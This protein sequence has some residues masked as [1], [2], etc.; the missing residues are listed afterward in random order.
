MRK[1]SHRQRN[2]SYLDRY[3]ETINASEV[4]REDT[5]RSLNSPNSVEKKP[6]YQ[7]LEKIRKKEPGS[8]YYQQEKEQPKKFVI[9]SKL[10]YYNISKLI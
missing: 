1:N 5:R 6:L 4:R 8:Q 7:E 10:P 2:L 9:K 3:S